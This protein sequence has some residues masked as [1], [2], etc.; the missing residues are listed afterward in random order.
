[1]ETV[2][3]VPVQLRLDTLELVPLRPL[4]IHAHQFVVTARKCQ[5]KIVKMGILLLQMAAQAHVFLSS[6]IH[7]LAVLH[8]QSIPELRFEEMELW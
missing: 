2:E 7:E 4:L 5:Q 1:M 6:V 3:V 8:L